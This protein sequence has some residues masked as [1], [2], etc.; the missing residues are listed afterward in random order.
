MAA[1]RWF[2][3]LRTPLRTRF[4]DLFIKTLSTKD[5]KQI[6]V[7]GLRGLTVAGRLPPSPGLPRSE[8]PEL[9]P[10]PGASDRLDPVFVTGR[11]RSGST[12]LW[13]LFRQVP[14]C[15]SFYEPLNERRWFDPARRGTR[16]DRTHRGVE[17]YWAE[18]EGLSY[19]SQYF[20]DDWAYKH[21]Y[22]ERSDW[23]PDLR[24]YIQ[25]LIDAAPSR[26]VLQFNRVD[27]RLP[28]LRQ[29]FPNAR[30]IHVYRHPRDQWCSSLVE[31]RQ[32]PKDR[33]VADFSAHDHFYLLPWAEDLSY[34]F[35]ILDPRRARH[36]Y[37]LFYLIWRL[38][39]DFGRAYTHASFGLEA[40]CESPRTEIERL[41][42]AAGVDVFDHAALTRLVAP[43]A[44]GK[45]KEYAPSSWFDSHEQR[46]EEALARLPRQLAG[47]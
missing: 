20:R 21:L 42:S 35:P 36:P 39:Y 3:G 24:A 25:G 28:W 7:D 4:F 27:F 19:L 32:F 13:N 33:T 44:Q 11:F 41:M 47:N 31:P 8:Y 12:L 16:I 10:M 23:E 14:D 34:H 46:C 2:A 38:S 40:L 26:A 45:W 30:L 37:E 17:N 15:T 22:L 9:A 1:S 18:Y 5:G 43:T 29:Q 6:L